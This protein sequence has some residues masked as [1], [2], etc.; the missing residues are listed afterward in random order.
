MKEV[1]LILGVSESRISQI[2][3]AALLQ[4]RIKL[5]ETMGSGR[6]RAKCEDCRSAERTLAHSER[7]PQ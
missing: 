5:Q 1:S 4:V 7:Y 2:H 6:V 3:S